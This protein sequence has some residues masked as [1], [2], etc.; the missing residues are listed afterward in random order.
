MACEICGINKAM[1]IRP[2]NKKKLCKDCFYDD[3][4]EDIHQL[5]M[6]TKMFEN[7]TKI[8]IGISGGKD[9]TVL[10]YVLDKLNKKHNY[11]KEI[12]LLCIDEGIAGYRDRSI[13]TVVAN[14][15]EL[16][17]RLKILSYQE[18]FGLTMDAVVEKIGT[19]GNCT[20]CGV[21][22]RQALEEAAQTSG[23]QCI[24]TGHNAD[25]MAETVL[26]NLMRG[27]LS[28]LKRCTLSKTRSKTIRSADGEKMLSL[29]RCKPFKYI[30]QKEIVFYA[31]FK[32]LNYF[33]TECTYSPGASRGDAREL[34]KRLESID[35]SIIIN[36]I[37]AAEEFVSTQ[38][39]SSVVPCVKCGHSTSSAD[40]KCTGCSL[41]DKLNAINIKK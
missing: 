36:I 4:E 19:R 21:F 39:D 24:V 40:G 16:G 27:D 22:R 12:V 34:I 26:L 31:Y 30:Y 8:G 25:D 37:K 18:L 11:G 20:Y 14:Q 33:S 29:P 15:K 17:H 41:V 1:L 5:I 38:E 6:S 3:F 13:D 32:K 9:S 10:A 7:C 2:S 23:A 35:S 28:R